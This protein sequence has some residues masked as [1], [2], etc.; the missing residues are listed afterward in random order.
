M[1]MFAFAW[2][3]EYSFPFWVNSVFDDI[4]NFHCCKIYS[5]SQY[6][7]LDFLITLGSSQLR[8]R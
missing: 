4:L 8:H 3:C 1:Q 2:F 6:I 5:S 7:K